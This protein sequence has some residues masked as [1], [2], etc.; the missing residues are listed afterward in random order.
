MK[1]I[2]CSAGLK[3]LTKILFDL[4]EFMMMDRT[5]QYKH[6]VQIR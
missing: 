5:Q 1:R 2:G 4:N 3:K 6:K